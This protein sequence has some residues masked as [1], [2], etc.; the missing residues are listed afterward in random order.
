MSLGTAGLFATAIPHVPATMVARLACTGLYLA[1]SEAHSSARSF[2]VVVNA[3]MP[4]GRRTCQESPTPCAS[5]PKPEFA[6]LTCGRGALT[7][8]GNSDF[9]RGGPPPSSRTSAREKSTP[10]AIV[11]NVVLA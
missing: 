2:S 6:A 11:A 5:R 9:L 4:R 10:T 7:S 1:P 8:A 3:G